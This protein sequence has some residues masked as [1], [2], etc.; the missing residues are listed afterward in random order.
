MVRSVV[1]ALRILVLAARRSTS[2]L[3]AGALLCLSAPAQAERYTIPWFEPP[4]AG[5]DPQGVLRI[6]NAAADAGTVTIHAIDDA[7][8]RTGTAVLALNG[9]AAVD[10]S[11][12][13]LQTGD[14][15][16]GL[17]SGVGNLSGGVLLALESD[18]PV[19]PLAL[20]RAA[21]GTLSALHDTVLSTTVPGTVGYRNDVA[22]FHPASNVTQP[23][24]LRLINPNDATA[25][26]AIDAWDDTGAAASGGTVQLTVP[27]GG[28]TTLTSRQLEAGDSS[29]FSGR[30]G[31]GVGNW[32]LSVSADRPIQVVNVAVGA[33]TGYWS[34]LSTTAVAGWAPRDASSFEARFLNRPN[35]LR[36]GMDRATLQVLVG[37]RFRH[38]GVEDGVE[39]I[40][41]GAYRYD[42]IGRDAGRLLL[43]FDGGER[44]GARLYFESA[45]SGWYGSGC[46]DNVEGVEYWTGGTWLGLDATAMP[47]DLGPGPDD[48]AY[49]VGTAIDALT[50]PEAG[51]GD[52]PLTYS[53]S[54]EVPGLHFDPDA[55]RLTGTPS[56]A[57]AW[58]MTF[59]VRDASGDTDWRQFNIAVQTAGGATATFGVGDTVSDLPTGSWVPDVI[60][61]GSF[62]SSGGNVTVRL[63][64]GR[65]IEEGEYRYTC[66]SAGGCTIENRRVTSG[67]V[68]QTSA[69]RAP[70]GGGTVEY[71]ALSDDTA[72]PSGITLAGGRFYVVDWGDDRVYAYTASGARDAA[73]SFE[74]DQDNRDPQGIAYAE[75]RF[76]VVD[77]ADDKVYAYTDAGR[78]DATADF[79][80]ASDNGSP[81]G[82]AYAEGRFY[83]VDFAD[84]K[85]Y[86][87][88][89]AG[90]RDAAAD[91]ELASDNGNPSG[92]GHA[93]GRL[94]VSDWGEDRV[95]AYTTAG[96]RDAA[97]DFEVASDN[98]SPAGIGYADGRLYLVDG[99][100]DKVYVHTASGARDAAADFD[101]AEDRR[102]AWG[103]A[104]AEG[105]LYVSDWGDDKVY[106]YTASGARV[107]AADLELANDNAS[108]LGIA[109]AEGRFYVVDNWN[110]KVYV[111]TAPDAHDAAADFE[112]G[113]GGGN[114]RGI[115]HAEGRFYV[116]DSAQRT[117]HAYTASGARDAASG[118][119]L[120]SENASPA[121]IAYAEGRF[122]V[123]DWFDDK[124]YAYTGSG[125]RDAASDI[126]LARD[127][128]SPVG[129]GYA[130]G[131]FF[132]VDH[133]MDRVY[134]YPAPSGGDRSPSFAGVSGPGNQTYN[135]GT[136][137]TALTLPAASGGDGALTYSLSPTV[138]GLIFNATASVRRLSGTPTTAGSYDMT[139]RVRD[140]DGDTDSL[141]FTI[142]VEDPGAGGQ[143]TTFGVGDTLSDLPTGF[144]TPDV[145]SGGSFS[146]SGGNVTIRLNDGGYIEEG[147][148]R[149]TCQ[150]A[151]GC[152]IENRRVSSGTVARTSAGTAPGGGGEDSDDHGGDRASATRVGAGS[153][154]QG[155]LSAGD[156]DYFRVDVDESG[157]LEVYTSGGVDTVGQLEDS[158]GSPVDN[159]DD[160]G[161]GT[162][163]RIAAD[164]TE[165]TYY[166]RVRGF[167]S[168]TGGEYTLHV[169]FAES[170]SEGTGPD[171]VV[172]AAS[173]SDSSPEAGASFTLSATVRNRGDGDSGATTLRYYRSTN[174]TISTS[175]T[176]VGTDAVGALSGFVASAES[177]SVTAPS[178]AGTYYYGAC[179]DSVAGETDTDNNCSSAVRVTVSAGTGTQPDDY[180][181][182]EGLRV[183]AGRVQYGIFSSGGCI[184]LS[185]TTINGVTYTVHSSKWQRRD[186][187]NSAWLDVP[188]TEQQGGLC[189]YN[190]TSAGEYRLVGEISINGE[191]GRYS[192]ENT[193]TV[194]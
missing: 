4:S 26:V 194:S 46:V 169:R 48:Q 163:F 181:P 29:A 21:D 107:A 147:D 160:G 124:V 87:Y 168:Q 188:G 67:T 20:M 176:A 186:S 59:R 58:V 19:V 54:P 184:R 148:Y 25:Q 171:L 35:V 37:N 100:D 85:V 44:C 32:R 52:G 137:I 61:G 108:P 43:E 138:P 161:A 39:V 113:I 93:E 76:H 60:S 175:D 131:R 49:T 149:F 55:R 84:D 27:P 101:L 56:E 8:V 64:D 143:P 40:E 173:V 77:N 50:L 74:L 182:L 47:L 162:N 92:I 136:A 191:R 105:R 95:Y 82:I 179:V 167:G 165:G 14:A 190:P 90:A 11:A 72:A 102:E 18:V 28:A 172:E 127:N 112:L 183:S 51:G 140:I 109:Y 69:G 45:T 117:V 33:G 123:S 135:V 154:T 164:V 99:N 178:G 114:A 57:G 42:R 65:Y 10:I 66:Q 132:V 122:Y 22:V 17:S 177:I 53:L 36:S 156:V 5:G 80:L 1:V 62:S 159:N 121:G 189:A 6:V 185:N 30:L 157:T 7:G 97:A 9:S 130:D 146:S 41:E 174:A 111:Y 24:R 23:S 153:D 16:K 98:G 145:T 192:S 180:T 142:T 89:D 34:N 187:A 193:L 68:V 88:T 116:I 119:E 81:R 120:A 170:T 125:A 63:N 2:L 155:S 118:F 129:I 110:D 96:A 91:F 73:A 83:V 78:R 38:T 3:L 79:E 115:A 144:W 31:A 126:E 128:F 104:H 13:E 103:I 166:V 71:F 139:Y 158:T 12:M 151:G 15:A 94:F 150:S 75:G 152:T 141:S 133:N 106:A 86:A 134:S 70:G